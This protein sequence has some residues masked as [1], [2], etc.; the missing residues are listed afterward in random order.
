MY[1]YSCQGDLHHIRQSNIPGWETYITRDKA[2]Y[3]DGCSSSKALS[4]LT[5][6]KAQNATRTHSAPRDKAGTW[7]AQQV[8]ISLH[9][10]RQRT[11]IIPSTRFGKRE[12]NPGKEW[13]ILSTIGEENPAMAGTMGVTQ[14]RKRA[15]LSLSLSLTGPALVSSSQ[16]TM[17]TSLVTDQ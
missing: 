15:S 17:R 13:V 10:Q 3:M 12:R 4:D 14:R 9:C 1:T 11:V 2:I 7:R 16:L 8:F 5:G 6:T